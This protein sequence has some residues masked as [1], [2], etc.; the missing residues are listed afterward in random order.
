MGRQ[1]GRQPVTPPVTTPLEDSTSSTIMAMKCR[2]LGYFVMPKRQMAE[3]E[4]SY[5][6]GKNIWFEFAGEKRLIYSGRTEED[7]W[8][9]MCEMYAMHVANIERE[10]G[11]GDEYLMSRPIR[12]FFI[13]Y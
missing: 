12:K 13:H 4:F 1:L 2:A 11:L 3:A 5:D 6:S 7:M 10:H 8:S 9:V